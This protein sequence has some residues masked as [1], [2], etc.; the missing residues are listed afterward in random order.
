MDMDIA[1]DNL[2]IKRLLKNKNSVLG[3]IQ[4]KMALNAYMKKKMTDEQISL[5]RDFYE[6]YE[7]KSDKINGELD[8]IEVRL[9]RND[10]KKEILSEETDYSAV[11]SA[12]KEINDRQRDAIF[13][14]NSIIERGEMTLEYI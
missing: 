7:E 3:R 9:A 2:N 14:L 6:E 12:L 10:V 8:E 4:T 5:F 13:T 1:Q 11:M